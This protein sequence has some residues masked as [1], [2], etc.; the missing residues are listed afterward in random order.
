MKMD[1]ERTRHPHPPR[2]GVYHET[3]PWTVC[4]I[5][6]GVILSNVST[7]NAEMG[8][9]VPPEKKL[10]A[11]GCDRINTNELRRR[12][13]QLEQ[14]GFDGIIIT[15]WP[16]K[17][18]TPGE[19]FT[20]SGRNA[21]WFGPT[22]HARNDFKLAIAD[23]KATKYKRFTDNF[24]DFQT[25]VRFD[26]K[27]EEAN[28]DWFDPH[29][30][31]VADNGAIAAYVA[32]EGGLKGLLID[33]ESYGGGLG[34]WRYPF[35]YKPYARYSKEAGNKPRSFDDCKAQVRKRGREF[36]QGVVRVYPTITIMMITDTGWGSGQLVRSFVQGMLEAKGRATI[37]DGAE[38]GYHMLTHKEFATMRRRA[39]SA[40][41]S[42]LFEGMEYGAGLW[43]DKPGPT[44]WHTDPKDFE[45][46]YRSP[47]RLEHAL[48][49]ALTVADRYVWVYGGS[50]LSHVD[51]VWWN[52]S[53][54][55]TGRAIKQIPQ[56]YLDAFKN[57]RKPHDLAWMPGGKKIV[58]SFDG[59]VV[60]EGEGIVDGPNLL[61][62]GDFAAWGT[63]TV[64]PPDG[65]TLLQNIPA[66]ISRDET[67]AKVGRYA[68]QLTTVNDDDF[69]HISLDQL[70]SATSLAGKTVTFS[71]WIRSN[72]APVGGLEIVGQN[73]I[74]YTGNVTGDGKWQFRS[75]TCK[76]PEEQTDGEIIFRL[77][78]FF[79][80]TPK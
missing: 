58:V 64:R 78:A 38:Q 47:E 67:S 31:K 9:A 2:M 21:R 80:Y 23:L 19:P 60:Q 79:A 13:E 35:R 7:A 73:P 61:T 39:E 3:Q 22:K 57:C 55:R 56:A 49:N 8:P 14:T 66:A 68:P 53:Y 40:A 20:K 34:P 11:F 77:R 36:M 43:W 62:N 50:T 28:L 18:R 65:W 30:S 5:L 26:P 15:V 74:K 10:I 17:F 72:S 59:A 24:M 16:D 76:I 45:K 12:I 71:A 44:G 42:S 54:G 27:P 37:V 51:S 75:I 6:V 29:W 25:T 4:T 48:Y 1:S 41:T 63:T 69:G 33:I 46:N 52:S 70:L 32:K